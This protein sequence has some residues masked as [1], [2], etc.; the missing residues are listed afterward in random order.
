VQ[1][2]ESVV[3]PTLTELRDVFLLDLGNGESRLTPAYLEALSRHLAAIDE[4]A[5]GRAVVTIA[6]GRF[7]STGLDLD[8]IAA[9]PNQARDL[10][11]AFH[12]AL[13]SLLTCN[14]YTVAAVQ[15][16]C[17]GGGAL[18]ALAHDAILMREDH[19]YFALPEIDLPVPFTDGMTALITAKLPPATA[20]AAMLTGRKYTGPQAV[21]AA[22][23]HGCSTAERLIPDA[24]AVAGKQAGKDA[25][26]LGTMKRRLYREVLQRLA[27]LDGD[28]PQ[29]F[30]TYPDRTV[31]RAAVAAS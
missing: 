13:A 6:T 5:E 22:I 8:W 11:G 20:A 18:L 9:H 1:S 31:T 12:A 24:L 15:G 28:L 4:S 23:S 7:F 17:L 26:T 2:P 30:P 16:H 21:D 14:A 29:S 27:V 3:L 10:V 25:E 19:G